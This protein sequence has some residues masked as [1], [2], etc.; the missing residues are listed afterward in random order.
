[1]TLPRPLLLLSAGLALLA[2]PGPAGADAAPGGVPATLLYGVVAPAGD[3]R[4]LFPVQVKV[5]ESGL[6]PE[7]YRGCL[8]AAVGRTSPAPGR[9][10]VSLTSL[11][12]VRR[13]GTSRTEVKGYLV[14]EDN[15]LGLRGTLQNGA[16]KIKPGQKVV[17]VFQ[18]S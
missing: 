4:T 17:I 11:T 10:N 3:T 18:E 13:E 15:Y 14:G 8:I 6:V 9:M 7:A 12:C 2:A 5:A 16:L 1:M